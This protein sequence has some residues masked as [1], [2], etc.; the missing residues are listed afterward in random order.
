MKVQFYEDTATYR[1]IDVS[2]FRE[3]EI[4]GDSR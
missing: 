3:R 1:T 2:T 4:G